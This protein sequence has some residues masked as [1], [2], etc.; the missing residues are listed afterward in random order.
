MSLFLYQ[1]IRKGQRKKSRGKR[2]IMI[3]N[4][5]SHITKSSVQDSEY[6]NEVIENLAKELKQ[7]KE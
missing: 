1:Q 4:L 5:S 6:L 3:G 2:F 7:L